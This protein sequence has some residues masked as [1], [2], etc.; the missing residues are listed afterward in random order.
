M[1]VLFFHIFQIYLHLNSI[2]NLSAEKT[3]L[4]KLFTPKQEIEPTK[5]IFLGDIM[6]GRNVEYL[7]SIN[8]VG[9]STEKIVDDLPSVD[10][11]IANFESAMAFPHL[12]TPSFNT[13]FSTAPWMLSVLSTLGVTHASLAN[14][15]SAD[16]GAAGYQNTISGLRGIGIVPF[17]QLFAVDT[18]SVVVIDGPTKIG[19]I[20][21]NTI[22]VNPKSNE[23][24]LRVED[25]KHNTD[26]QIAYIHWGEE[27]ELLHSMNQ[28]ALAKSLVEMGIDAIV[29][30][31]PHVA[32]DIQLVN[33]VPIFYSLG[34]FI[35][36]QYFSTEVQEGYM[37]KMTVN[38]NTPK[39]SFSIIPVTSL[40][41]RSQPRLMTEDEKQTFIKSLAARS[42]N[43]IKDLILQNN[44]SVMTNLAD[45]E[46][47]SIITQ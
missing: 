28:E 1:G 29:G 8:G 42:D 25:M 26:I 43:R 4:Y 3:F 40:D 20:A 24:Q 14:N 37:L 15:H 33:G 41:S 7:S 34:N 18:S 5:I 11:V 16:Y 45:E 22:Y 36:D 23:L 44:I 21:I 35:F 30:H 12:R 27:Y 31:H 2:N 17:G 32:Q 38:N 13:T 10:A 47:I 39:I 46:E 19:V 9:Y 6:L